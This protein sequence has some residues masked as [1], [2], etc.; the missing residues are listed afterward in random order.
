MGAAH[1][2][3][4]VYSFLPTHGWMENAITQQWGKNKGEKWRAAFLQ[5]ETINNRK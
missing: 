4:V 2:I 5:S 3:L 1:T